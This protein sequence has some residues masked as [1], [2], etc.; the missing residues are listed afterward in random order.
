MDFNS[1]DDQIKFNEDRL[2]NESERYN[3]I[4]SR[5]GFISILYTLFAAFGFQIISYSL[6]ENDIGWTYL[7]S[8]F[9]FLISTGV[10]IIYAIRLLIPVDIAH[11]DLPQ[12]FYGDLKNQYLE[13]G[14]EEGDVNEYIK[15]TYKNQLEVA[16][17][18]NFEVNNKKSKFHYYS[19][20]SALIAI[21]PYLLCI[22]IYVSNV[23][24]SPVK[25]ELVNKIFDTMDDKKNSDSG[26]TAKPSKQVDTAKVIIKA[27]IMIREN[28]D[29]ATKTQSTDGRQGKKD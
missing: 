27:P 11:C 22:G 6:K 9:S 25:V 7:A 18:S 3:E 5:I 21:L 8:L 23:K 14:I 13:D 19:F 2:K 16:I 20:L 4:K 17:K 26:S 28:K 24:E 10:S 29:S 15:H 1:I 12:Y